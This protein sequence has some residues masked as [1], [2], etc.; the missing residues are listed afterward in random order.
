MAHEIPYVATATVSELRDLEAKVRRA[1][2]F[3]GARYIHILVPCPLGWGHGSA[4][5]IRMAR[6]AHET[7]L[8]PVFEA[9][10]GEVKS[11]SKI[12]RQLPVEEY[13]KPQTRFAHLFKPPGHAD[14]IA[15]IQA[16]AD[17]NVRRFDLIDTTEAE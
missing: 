13:L 2:E 5:T 16:M 1:M 12:R 4:E 17:K 3:R 14:L 10:H 8:F 9:E 7:G 11:V 6:L 15:Q